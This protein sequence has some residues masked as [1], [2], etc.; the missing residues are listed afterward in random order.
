MNIL[1]HK[2]GLHFHVY[3]HLITLCGGVFVW[4]VS[5]SSVLYYNII[6]C[7]F[8]GYCIYGML[9]SL[10]LRDFCLSNVIFS[11]LSNG[12]VMVEYTIIYVYVCV[13]VVGWLVEHI[14]SVY[15][16]NYYYLSVIALNQCI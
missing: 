8:R 15:S 11:T 7:I 9:L 4:F 16:L 5:D 2:I 3:L 12:M 6:E 13:Y 10:I 14:F 1:V